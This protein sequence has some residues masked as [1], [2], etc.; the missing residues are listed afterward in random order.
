MK[1]ILCRLFL[2]ILFFIP[3]TAFSGDETVGDIAEKAVDAAFSEFERQI[4][5]GYYGE[6][7]AGRDEDVSSEDD[8]NGV[9]KKE[10]KSKKDKKAMK[11]KKDKKKGLP[12]GI[13]KKLERGGQLPPGIANRSLPDDLENKLPQAAGGFER[14]ESDGKVLLVETATG[15]IVDM[16]DT[17]SKPKKSVSDEVAETKRKASGTLE[18]TGEP[19]NKWW[20]FWK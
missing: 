7:K 17:I 10:K 9:A 15:I 6:K 16:I 18:E 11:D 14:V 5:E 20:Q 1:P 3:I 4:I 12:P 13:A 2:S 19:E 8:D